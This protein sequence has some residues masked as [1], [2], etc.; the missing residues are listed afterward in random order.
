MGTVTIPVDNVGAFGIA[1]DVRPHELPLNVWT[2]GKNVRMISGFV[3]KFLGHEEVFGTPSV[4]PYFALPVPTVTTYLWLYAG[5]NKVY[6][7]DGVHN[8]VT[9]QTGAV[10][11]DY[12]ATSLRNW[13]GSLLGG[14]PVINNGID[15][16]QQLLPVAAG[17]KLAALTAWPSTYLC[18]SIKAYKQFL[19]ALDITKAG[20]RYPHMV[21][22]SH[23]SDPGA[24]PSSWDETDPTLDAGEVE[25]KDSGGFLLDSVPLRDTNILYKE[26]Q[27]IGQQFIGGNNIFRFYKIFDFGAISRRCA[28]EFFNG[29][30]AVFSL[31]DIVQHDGQRALSLLSDRLRSYVFNNIDST[32]MLTSFVAVNAAAREVWF[33]YPETG[34]S[35]PNKAV[36]WN[37]EKGTLGVRD[38]NSVAHIAK[39]QVNPGVTSDQW[40]LSTGTWATDSASWGLRT[41]VPAQEQMLICGTGE[42]K[43]HLADVGNTFNGTNMTAYIERS[44][45][46]FPMRVGKPPDFTTIKQ[47]QRVFPRIE[48]TGGGQ[49][50][51]YV[52]AQQVIGGSVEWAPPQVFTIGESEFVDSDMTG[53][54]HA[55]KFESV[56]NIDWRLHGYDVELADR[57]RY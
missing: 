25:L 37:F 42:T 26:D 48:G 30:H 21:K 1:T 57:G 52:G 27:T 19:V 36:V 20:V 10:D 16:P 51:V 29:A 55:L 43:L 3:E 14:I 35:L 49:I 28:V 38:L 44:G 54:L 7:Y 23:P 50:N 24:V 53:R 2:S 13:T 40:G 6:V 32:N 4:A 17:T 34:S 31:N 45:L 22:W 11:V 5:L 46:G 8:N 47:I 15:L 41:F 12:A 18:G 33:C 56:S 39:G 9:R